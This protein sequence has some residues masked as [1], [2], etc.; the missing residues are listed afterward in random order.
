MRLT[1]Y[2]E[3]K[4]HEITKVISDKKVAYLLGEV[5]SGKTGTSLK[6]AELLGMKNVLFITK[7]KAI[8]D[9]EKQ[10][11]SFGFNF[12]LT[13]VNYESLHNV[14]DSFDFVIVDEAHSISAFPKPNKRTKDIKIKYGHLPIL[15]LSG[16]PAVESY[17]QWYHQFYISSFSPFK[18]FKNFYRFADVYVN[19]Q[20][21]E[22]GTHKIID[23]KGAK[24]D[25]INAKINKYIVRM[26]Q[27]EA[28]LETNINEQ[29]IYID[30]PES[31]DKI[32]KKLLKDR[33]VMLQDGYTIVAETPVKLQS[34][35]HQ[36]YNGTCIIENELFEQ[37]PIT[38]ST[39]K[40]DFIKEYFKGNK[41][42][43]MYYYQQEKKVLDDAG[44]D[45]IQQMATEGVSLQDYDAIVFLN[46]G[47]S[48]K[49]YIQ[50]RDRLSSL[51]RTRSN[52]VYF[53]FEKGGIN[54]KIYERVKNKKDFN[55]R[56][57]IKEYL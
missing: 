2:Q 55:L 38:L 27:S 56:E 20:I 57:F 50:S 36:I 21:K 22:I 6:V 26:S 39:Y 40:V 31:I 43:V 29:I 10:H 3:K 25:D 32:A 4:A 34:K 41:I 47:F 48:G 52:D 45:A 44:L 17:S 33:V 13:V 12:N 37:K 15:L 42:I 7:K 5:R 14:D 24:V 11:R 16:T 9:I 23:Y 19:K 8:S 53:I 35:I 18:A 46:F 1:E 51:T 28:G 49:N 30:V 54:E